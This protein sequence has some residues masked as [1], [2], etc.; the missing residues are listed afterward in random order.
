MQARIHRD[1]RAS[2]DTS[3]RSI[4]P[5][6]PVNC[7]STFIQKSSRSNMLGIDPGTFTPT[8]PAKRA[9]PDYDRILHPIQQ[10]LP[11]GFWPA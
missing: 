9:K 6:L 10:A 5:C 2:C 4:V 1:A 8:K 3:A 7:C 11:F